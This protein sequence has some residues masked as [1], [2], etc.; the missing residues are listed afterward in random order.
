[1]GEGTTNPNLAQLYEDIVPYRLR[2]LLGFLE[3]KKVYH[4]SDMSWPFRAGRV[5]NLIAIVILKQVSQ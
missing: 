4:P 1:V 5:A 3:L 2:E